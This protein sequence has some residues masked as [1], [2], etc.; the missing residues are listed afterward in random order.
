MACQRTETTAGSKARTMM[1][2]FHWSLMRECT[3]NQ[4]RD[5]PTTGGWSPPIRAAPKPTRTR[6]VSAAQMRAYAGKAEEYVDAATDE[7][8][9][10]RCIAAT[11]LAQRAL[12]PDTEGSRPTAP[13]L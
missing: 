4:T 1:S 10:G 7:I 9:S 2:A 3:R 5:T 11:S 13:G 6:P 12:S 8:Q